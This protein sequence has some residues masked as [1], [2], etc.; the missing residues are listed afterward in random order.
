MQPDRL[1]VAV[2]MIDQQ[3]D[4]VAK[5][6]QDLQGQPDQI[7]LITLQGQLDQIDLTVR[8]AEAA[9]QTDLLVHQAEA[10][11]EA[12]LLV[13]VHQEAEAVFLQAEAPLAVVLQAEVQAAAEAL[14][15]ETCKRYKFKRP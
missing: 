15:E 6:Q 11:Q 3:E 7:N 10:L 14:Q 5:M 12:Y 8:Q 9:D 1:E 2:L 4:Q 13:E